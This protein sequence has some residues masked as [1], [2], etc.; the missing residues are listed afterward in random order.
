MK[1]DLFGQTI[2][3]E[4]ELTKQF[5]KNDS[6]N[7]DRLS[8]IDPE[9]YNRA[10]DIIGIPWKKLESYKEPDCTISDFHHNNQQIWYMPDEYKNFDI[11]T[12]IKLKCNNDEELNRAEYE[13]V[14]FKQY[15][16]VD[17]LKYMVYLIDIMKENNIIWGVG[18]GSSVAS[19]VLFLIGLNKVNPMK[20]NLNIKE[21]LK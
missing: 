16:L 11:E 8:I 21:F 20:F 10:I 2:I 3:N 13:L 6:I 14:L 15:E 7:I 9:N 17:M 18:R 19:F 12:Y 5:Y 1:R 4:W